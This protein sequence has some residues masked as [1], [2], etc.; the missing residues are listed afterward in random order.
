MTSGAYDVT[1]ARDSFSRRRYNE[2]HRTAC[3]KK[4]ADIFQYETIIVLQSLTNTQGVLL[5]TLTLYTIYDRNPKYVSYVV[6]DVPYYRNLKK[7]L[8][9]QCFDL[10]VFK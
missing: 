5:V 10:V 6:C 8:N 9:L 1:F 7:K 4:Y 2:I 3:R